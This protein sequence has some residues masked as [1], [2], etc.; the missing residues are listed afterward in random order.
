MERYFEDF[1][2]AKSL[3]AKKG[4][5]QLDRGEVRTVDL[6]C[7]KF[8]FQKKRGELTSEDVKREV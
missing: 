1:R 3:F 5:G 8:G 6:M 4:F 7:V 2:H